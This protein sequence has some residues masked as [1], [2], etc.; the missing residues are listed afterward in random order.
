[1]RDPLS[2]FT[3]RVQHYARYRPGYPAQVLDLF[4]ARCSFRA[5]STVA[6]IGSGTGILSRMLLEAGARLFAVE[7][8]Q[9]MRETAERELSGNLLFTSV[10]GTAEDT[11]LPAESVDLI[12]AAQ[13]FHWFNRDLARREFTRILRPGGSVVLLWNERLAD[14]TP[15]L[16]GYEALLH[17][18]GQD[19]A[20]VDHR[21]VTEETIAAFFHPGMA[22]HTAFP[23][24]QHFDFEGL[25]G[26][27]LSSSYMPNEGDA[28]FPAMLADLK[29][30][31]DLHA[32]EGRVTFEYRTNVHFGKLFP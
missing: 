23:N 18:Y 22:E 13:A 6:D 10:P 21:N 14:T 19:Y 15:F 3:G 17:R 1:M 29:A 12:T 2:R 28:R 4:R 32:S 20:Q 7:P 26:R 11:H 25:R 9:E 5:G 16:R 31:F 8:N 27:I 24:A 30:L